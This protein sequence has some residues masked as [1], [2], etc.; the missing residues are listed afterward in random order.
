MQSE[1]RNIVVCCDGTGNQFGDC[2]SNVI[3][4]YTMLCVNQRQGA[5]YH[6]GLGTMGAP[7]R[8]SWLGKK[9]SQLAGLAFGAGFL[10]NLGDAYQYLMREYKDGDQIFLLGFSRGAYTVRALAGALHAYG[11]LCPGNEGHLPYLLRLYSDASRKAYGKNLTQI[12]SDPLSEAFKETFSRTI[13]VRFVGIWDTVS[14]VGWIYDPVKLLFDGQNP[15]IQIGRHAISIDEHRC[16][17]QSNLWGD[18]LP[19]SS[20]PAL[21]G[22]QQDIVQAWFPGVHSDVGG[23]YG[24]AECAPAQ[25]ALRW[26]VSEAKAAG[27]IVSEAKEKAVFGEKPPGMDIL[28]AMYPPPKPF[29]HL[30][31]SFTPAWWAL[32]LFPHKYF[33]DAGRKHWQLAPWAHRRELPDGALLHPSTVRR[34]QQYPEYQPVNLSREDI[35]PIGDRRGHLLMPKIEEQLRREGFSAY[36]AKVAAKGLSSANQSSQP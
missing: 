35:V 18:P 20:T 29:E 17:F 21:N 22:A 26:I 24:Q 10:S 13:A 12:P 25:D 5:Y 7:N 3:K 33:D 31:Q 30:H 36:R 16:F 6:P 19:R 2:N 32:E 28:N 34:L 8:T 27:L 15:I 1:S 4:I 23:S 14:S 11:L 9:L